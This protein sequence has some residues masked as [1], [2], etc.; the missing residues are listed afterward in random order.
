MITV[1][2]F[3][4]TIEEFL[5]HLSFEK[6]ISSH[7]QRA[8][9]IDLTQFQEYWAETTHHEEIDIKGALQKYLSH[10]KILAINNRSIA[11][12]LSCFS[13]FLKF[14]LKK[15]IRIDIEIKRPTFKRKLPTPLTHEKLT[16]ILNIAPEALPSRFPLRDKAIIELLY[17]TGITSMEITRICINDIDFEN[18]CIVIIGKK[19]KSRTVFFNEIARKRLLDYFHDER[20]HA[21]HIAEP[22]FLN[23]CGQQLTTRSIQKICNMFKLFLDTVEEVTPHTFRHSFATHLIENGIDKKDLKEFLGYSALL[24]TEQYAHVVPKIKTKRH[25]STEV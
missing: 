7:T 10:L 14:L 2:T 15:N 25:P 20:K 23:H 17:A 1:N 11:R 12:K 19:N 21:A 4:K 16:H 13:S 22:F 18:R 6:K 3:S 24:S 5:T 9:R 8:Y